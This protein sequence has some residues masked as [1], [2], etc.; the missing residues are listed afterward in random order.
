[1]SIIRLTVGGVL[2]T[3]AMLLAGDALAAR[4]VSAPQDVTI[5]NE[6]D[7]TSILTVSSIALDDSTHFSLVPGGTCPATPF[8]LAAGASCTQ[9]VVFD[10]QAVGPLS[11]TLLV[12]S[13]ADSV[14]NDQVLLSGNGTPA[15]TPVLSIAPDP[16][17]FGLV[18]AADLPVTGDFTLSNT[19]DVG[20]TL[21]ITSVLL[22]GDPEYSIVFDGCNGT[23]LADGDS[24]IVTIQFNAATDGMFTGQIDVQSTANNVSAA[25]QGATQIPTQLAF[26]VQPTDTT[27]NQSISPAVVV[28]VQD[29]SGTLVSLDN[30]TIIQLSLASDPSGVATLGGTVSA[31]VSGGQ[32]TFANLSIDQVG[33]GFSLLAE[34]SLAALSPDTS[35]LFDITA[36]A[37]ASLQILTQPSDTVVGQTMA[38][39]VTVQVLDAFGFPV[40]AD[41]S[42]QISLALSGGTPGAVLSGG[43]PVSVS[44]G[45]ASFAGLSVDQVGTAY[46]LTPS[47]SPGGLAGPASAV[48]DVLE[49]GSGTTIT[50]V[51]P[52]GSQTVGQ[53]YTVNVSVTGFNPTGIVTVTDGAGASCQIVLPA[54]SCDLTSTTVGPKVLTAN[55][56][57][58]ANN[59]PSSDTENYT[60]TQATAQ[61]Q[62][63]SIAPPVSQAVNTPY[64]VNVSVTGFNPTGTITVDDGDGNSCQIVLPAVSC[65]LTS[66]SVGPKT[67]TAS[68]PGDANNT[69]DSDSQAYQ[70]VAGAPAQLVFL[71]QPSDGSSQVPLVPAVEVQVQD[72]FGNP[73]LSD[74]STSVS[75]SLIGGAPG[76]TLSGGGPVTAVAGVASFP[77]LSVDLAAT[78]YQLQAAA[79][80]LSGDTSQ[81]FDIGPGVPVALQFDVQPTNTLVSATMSPAVTVSVRDAVG[82]LVDSDNTAVVELSLTGG[83]PGAVLSGGGPTVVSAGV[84]SFAALSVDLS[85]TGYQLQASHFNGGFSG[86]TSNSFAITASASTTNIVSITPA[87]SQ[88]VGQPYSVEVSVTGASPTGQVT[89]S[90]GT[91]A[92]CQFTL[93]ATSCNLTSTSA[94]AKT[95]T[96]SYAGDDNNASSSDSQAYQIDQAAS[97][98]SII[99]VVPAAEQIVDQPYTVNVSVTGFNPSGQVTVSDGQGASCQFTLPQTSCAL[100]STSVGPVT[101]EASYPGDANNQAS[102]DTEAYDIVLA[103]STTTILGITPPNEQVVDLPYTVTVSVTGDSPTGTVTVDDG[104]GAQCTFDLPDTSCDLV[105]TT[106]GP[107]TIT[108]S[109]PGDATNTPSSDTAPYDIISSGP[110]ELV[111]AVEP[112]L[113]IINGPLLPGLVVHVLNSQGGLVGDDNTTV[114]QISIAT[115]PT[116]GTLN[117]TTTLQVTNGVADFADLS[118][119]RRGQ[120]YQLQASVLSRGI[121]S[122]VTAPFNV[123]DDGILQDRFETPTD[124]IFRDRFELQ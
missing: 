98:T 77:T 107:R 30:S 44:A 75:M 48:F 106:V 97:T 7:P 63:D 14:I 3:A 124:D 96:A 4:G 43:G 82:N 34:D 100:T 28:E 53:A 90:D 87:G 86:D 49:A 9:Q 41:N 64:T 61:V 95:I 85:G 92:S 102:S 101:L 38:P 6:G 73:V 81:A 8:D 91:G 93:P 55:Y 21:D 19:G 42:T 62:I 120:G 52:A 60:I 17:D 105:S 118:I 46:Q 35:V 27:V 20:T 2:L 57:G 79:A 12:L 22:S 78:G 115:N 72:A 66:T 84:A 121:P 51:A 94:G 59:G 29:A 31:Q 111:F 70:I 54:T 123:V 116:G 109:Y 33:T 71:V 117:G 89:V 23:T 113:G 114:V 74:N 25:I 26:F 24:C 83:T 40:T 1:M 69:A 99:S 5:S 45:V 11:A 67:I 58:D 88:T 122:I 80:G 39:A 76:A 65:D 103:D 68:Y 18:A 119:D 32:A 104:A 108:A 47:G 10:P 36:G 112:T 110:A 13:D 15:P 37:P 56:P 16:L 50:S